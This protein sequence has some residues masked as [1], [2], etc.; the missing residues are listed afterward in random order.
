MEIYCKILNKNSINEIDNILEE[1]YK[2]HDKLIFIFDLTEYEN[3]IN[4]RLLL[5]LKPVI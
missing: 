5:K 4:L 3:K 2:N 1:S